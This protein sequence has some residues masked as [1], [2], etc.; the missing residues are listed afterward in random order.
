VI[1][2]CVEFPAFTVTGVAA[3]E[4]VP[5][6]L[7]IET[8]RAVFTVSAPELAAMFK[9]YFPAGTELAAESVSTPV[10][11]DCPDWKVAL[12]P[13]GRPEITEKV[14]LFSAP[15]EDASVAVTLAESP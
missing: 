7:V 13:C 1:F 11:K 10:P 15:A 2:D 12:N 4:K 9:V 3:I 14:G 5:T 8:V 6:G